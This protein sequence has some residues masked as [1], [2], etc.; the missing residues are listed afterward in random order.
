MSLHEF[1]SDTVATLHNQVFVERMHSFD[2]DKQNGNT[3][4]KV[5][6]DD[7]L[8]RLTMN[9]IEKTSN[10]LTLRDVLSLGCSSK[11]YFQKICKEE[12]LQIAVKP[13]EI[14]LQ[15]RSLE[16]VHDIKDG[17]DYYQHYNQ[18][19]I[20]AQ[21]ESRDQMQYISKKV[22]KCN[23][24]SIGP[25]STV[26]LTELIKDL[27]TKP[28]NVD[29]ITIEFEH[30]SKIPLRECRKKWK[31]LRL[32]HSKKKSLNEM[33]INHK[34]RSMPFGFLEKVMYFFE[35]KKLVLNGKGDFELNC[36]SDVD[37]LFCFGIREI[38]MNPSI[39]DINKTLKIHQYHP[40]IETP[41][42]TVLDVRRLE[43]A[44]DSKVTKVG[45]C[46]PFK[47]LPPPVPQHKKTTTRPS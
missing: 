30:E 42:K 25:K 33:I 14:L 8:N 35:T 38:T 27:C 7:P 44:E 2:S 36:E 19:L 45:S 6:I 26:V 10:F 24:L 5:I 28:N 40:T 37:R 17:N 18:V 16:A 9:L 13:A 39:V 23:H 1:D 11:W 46:L 15:Q 21:P 29:F 20:T 4:K 34:D 12:F 3:R 43:P 22:M 41:N 47:N 32:D 31:Y